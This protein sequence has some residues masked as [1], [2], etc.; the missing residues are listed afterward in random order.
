MGRKKIFPAEKNIGR[1]KT[2][3]KKYRPEK[4]GRCVSQHPNQKGTA[5]SDQKTVRPISVIAAEISASWKNVHYTAVPYLSAM[6][7][8]STVED[9]YGY[10][11]A[12]GIILYF[13]SNARSWR[14]E[15]AK[16]I[17][18]ELKA[19]VASR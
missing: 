14:G 13:L 7:S 9:N 2:C 11:D 8:L 1:K 19:M 12:R 16:R 3:R 18:A 10:D 6:R 17:K 5:M 4:T 15:D